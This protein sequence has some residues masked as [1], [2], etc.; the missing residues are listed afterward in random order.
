MTAWQPESGLIG[1]GGKAGWLGW[2]QSLA[3]GKAERGPEAGL[4]EADLLLVY[5]G[6]QNK[7]L[8]TVR[9]V[10]KDKRK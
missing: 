10:I 4:T 3:D 5:V 9:T 1:D 2:N 7:D 8:N 6:W